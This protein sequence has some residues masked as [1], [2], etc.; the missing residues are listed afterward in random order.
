MAININGNNFG[1]AVDG[2]LTIGHVSFGLGGGV[3]SASG[4]RREEPADFCPPAS[5]EVDLAP[6]EGEG[7]S[8]EDGTLPQ[9]FATEKARRVMQGLQETGLLDGSLQPVGLSWA[10]K[11]YLAQQIAYKLGITH[12][13]KVFGE[14][15][16]CDNETLRNGYN[17]AKEMEKMADFD[18][19]IKGVVG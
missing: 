1:I 7:A 3:Q 11:G 17:R 6:Q 4:I 2:N 10:E 16:H 14:L 13:W 9:V 15:W 12:Q 5:E 19:K 8:P 18:K